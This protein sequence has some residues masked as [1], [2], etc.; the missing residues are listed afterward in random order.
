MYFVNFNK[1]KYLGHCFRSTNELSRRELTMSMCVCF[2]TDD[3]DVRVPRVLPLISRYLSYR[4]IN[5]LFEILILKLIVRLAFRIIINICVRF[6]SKFEFISFF[7]ICRGWSLS[8]MVL[9]S[10]IYCFHGLYLVIFSNRKKRNEKKR[11][12]NL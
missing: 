2:I 1:K 3:D 5:G 10:G 4:I 7:F 12:V 9:I 8:K 11:K 6:R